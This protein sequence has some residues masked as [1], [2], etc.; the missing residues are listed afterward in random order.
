MGFTNDDND[1]KYNSEE[2]KF[3]EDNLEDIIE[4]GLREY[5]CLHG[6]LPDD[7][8]NPSSM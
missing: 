4:I 5:G 7:G 1:D 3:G 6:Y 8:Y 2:E